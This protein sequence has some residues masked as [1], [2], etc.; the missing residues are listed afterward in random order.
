VRNDVRE[1]DAKAAFTILEHR[2]LDRAKAMAIESW[3]LRGDYL[4]G[5]RSYIERGD[6]SICVLLQKATVIEREVVRLGLMAANGIAPAPCRHRHDPPC[7][8]DVACTS[9]YLGDQQ[10]AREAC[11]AATAGVRR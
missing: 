3:L 5:D 9:R 6:R 4:Q 8:D 1:C 11:T 10:A 7:A 2:T